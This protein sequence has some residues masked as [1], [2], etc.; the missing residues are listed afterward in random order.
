MSSAALTGVWGRGTRS[1]YVAVRRFRGVRGRAVVV[2]V[3]GWVGGWVRE[4]R[5]GAG[6][7]DR[8]GWVGL[9]A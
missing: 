1:I 3:G 7:D 6:W 9:R 4:G 2:V 5:G 8:G